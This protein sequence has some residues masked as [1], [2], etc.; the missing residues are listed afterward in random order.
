VGE[1][2]EKDLTA[3]LQSYLHGEKLKCEGVNATRSG[4]CVG[5]IDS[6]ALARMASELN[7]HEAFSAGDRNAAMQ[8]AAGCINRP[9]FEG[10]FV[11]IAATRNRPP[12]LRLPDG[13]SFE[14]MYVFWA[15]QTNRM[16]VAVAYASG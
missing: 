16:C 9:E 1:G 5:S 6:I 12:T 15:Q 14:Y 3:L 8:E 13:S 11:K 4:F 2:L 7:L 10:A